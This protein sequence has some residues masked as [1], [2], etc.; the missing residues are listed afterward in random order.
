MAY[1]LG[2]NKIL[3]YGTDGTNYTSIVGVTSCDIM[4]SGKK[5]DTTA[6]DDSG[7]E[8]ILAGNRSWSIDVTLNMD[9]AQA[10]QSAL[11][12][13][14]LA[15]TL[16]YWR[17]RPLGTSTGNFQYVGQ[18]YILEAPKLAMPNDDK[19]TMTMK[20]TGTGALTKSTQ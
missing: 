7:W 19:I 11:I 18:G 9:E 4:V 1:A 14:A 15:Q 12:A 2:R 13:G 8:T 5:V 3:Q 10:S 16:Y 17:M 20:I 6:H